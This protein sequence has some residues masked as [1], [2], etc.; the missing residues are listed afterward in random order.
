M[1]KKSS[2]QEL[3]RQMGHYLAWII[4]MTRRFSLFK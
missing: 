1:L 4:H 3:L 2:F